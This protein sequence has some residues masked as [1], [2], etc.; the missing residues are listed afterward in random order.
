MSQGDEGSI[1]NVSS[2]SGMM[3]L[4]QIVPCSAAKAALNAITLCFAHEYGPKVRVNTLSA[5]PFLTDIAKSWPEE[6][7]LHQPNAAGRSGPPHEVVTSALY[8]ASAASS[9]TTGALLRVDGG[10]W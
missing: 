10:T 2:T 6:A 8:F 9:Y 5:G 7:R 1:I 3:P 4:P